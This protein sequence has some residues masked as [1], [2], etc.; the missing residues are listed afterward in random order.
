ME[1]YHLGFTVLCSKGTY[2]RTLAVDIGKKLGFPAHMSH[3]I[4]TGS[5]DFTLDECITLDESARY[6]RRRHSR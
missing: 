1:Q 4:R 6:K 5:G 3:L 2:V